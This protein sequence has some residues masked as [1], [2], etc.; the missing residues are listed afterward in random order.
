[1]RKEG[2]CIGLNDE[3]LVNMAGKKSPGEE[4]KKDVDFTDLLIDSLVERK[5]KIFKRRVGIE[6]V[7][8]EVLLPSYRPDKPNHRD[9]QIRKLVEFLGPCFRNESP[10]NMLIYGKT[11]T[12]KTLITKH[13]TGKIQSRIKEGEKI[14][15]FVTYINVQ[16]HHTKYRILTKM[17]E[18]L[19]IEV[20]K[21]GLATDM[22]LDT[23]KKT[24]RHEGRQLLVIIDEI[25]L[26]IKSKEKDD[27]LYMLTRMVEE[28]P[29]V[30]ISI[31][32]ISNDV[33]F[34]SFLGIRVL[35][36]LNAQE[37]IFPPY[38]MDELKAILKERGSLAFNQGAC[39]EDMITTIASMTA[40]EHGDA[41]KAIALLLKA[42]DI[43]DING[44]AFVDAEHILKARDEL[45]F[46]AVEGFIATLPTQYKIVL[47]GISNAEAVYKVAVNTGNLLRIYYDLVKMT[48]AF[49]ST[50]GKRRLLQILTEMREHGLIELTVISKGRYGRFNMARSL[51]DRATIERVISKDPKLKPLLN[52]VP[53]I[54]NLDNFT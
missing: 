17:C 27:L 14:G 53:H 54:K 12:G 19:G 18:D 30:A 47:I 26:L 36:S 20:P 11:G 33:R 21:T 15:P 35:S 51:I 50:I 42:G 24:L 7:G 32:G 5:G 8:R 2:Q 1:G 22:V 39:D 43:A 16:M 25:D 52:Y 40:K 28:E 49:T 6:L 38:T 23:L 29:S 9:E 34:K 10:G 41:R 48:D 37:L 45:E 46:D 4:E 31:I 3:D 44:T 13:V